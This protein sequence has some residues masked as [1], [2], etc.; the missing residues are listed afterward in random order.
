MK[1]ISA[2]YTVQEAKERLKHIMPQ[3][4]FIHH[5]HDLDSAAMIC[6]LVAVSRNWWH[7]ADG[8]PKKRNIGEMIALIHSEVSEALEGARRDLPSDHIP[9]SLFGEEMGD[10]F[11]RVGDLAYATGVDMA[12][13]TFTKLSFNFVREDHSLESRNS[14]G[15]KQI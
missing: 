15:G 6:H 4:N 1:V 2:R 3:G 7:E 10:V 8:T 14:P 5:H 12:W 13:T 11:I 9:G